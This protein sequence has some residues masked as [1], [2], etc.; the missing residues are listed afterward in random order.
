M[1]YATWSNAAFGDNEALISGLMNYQR[2]LSANGQLLIFRFLLVPVSKDFPFLQICLRSLGDE[3]YLPD[4]DDMKMVV[5]VALQLA[6]L[7]R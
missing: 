3:I 7:I 5:D 2:A 6:F 1:G 4:A